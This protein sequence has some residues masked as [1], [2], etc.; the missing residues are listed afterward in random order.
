MEDVMRQ[1]GEEFDGAPTRNDGSRFVVTGEMISAGQKT[2]L[3]FFPEDVL[4]WRTAGLSQA[5]HEVFRAMM[6]AKEKSFR[7][8]N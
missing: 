1:A 7:E 4:S 5:V 2:L 8:R 3:A 6:A